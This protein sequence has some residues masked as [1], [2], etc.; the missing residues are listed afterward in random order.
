MKAEQGFHSIGGDK[1]EHTSPPT[2]QG[3]F[4]VKNCRHLGQF[5]DLMRT[6]VKN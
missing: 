5:I 4:R 6:L 1:R 2:D 3:M